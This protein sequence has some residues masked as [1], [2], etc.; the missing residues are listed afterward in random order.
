MPAAWTPCAGLTPTSELYSYVSSGPSAL[1]TLPCPVN[2]HTLC[3][4]GRL[5]RGV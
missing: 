4:Q 3:C 5:K 1:H 2:Q